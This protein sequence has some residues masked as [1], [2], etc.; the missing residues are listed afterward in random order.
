MKKAFTLIEML[1]CLAVIAIVS[2]M[3]F[4]VFRAKPN[5]NMVMFRKAYNITS[6][7]LYE[8]F[9][10]STYYE[11]GS[12]NV[13]EPTAEVINNERPSGETKFCKVFGH[14]VNTIDVPNCNKGN[15]E[16]SFTTLDGI[17]WYLPPKTTS[18]NFNGEEIIR[19]DVNG[20]DNLP[21]CKDGSECACINANDKNCVE[22]DIFEFHI[23]N[24][25]K[26]YIRGPVAKQYLK[27]SR[28]ISK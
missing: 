5:S 15:S 8:L 20:A 22:P 19:V 27:N 23:V 18:G 28:K 7:T 6:T 26:M 1:V 11:S 13:L 17:D 16:P 10:A 14:F 12:L 2:V 24:S 21:N 9:Q 25:G 4:S 3:L